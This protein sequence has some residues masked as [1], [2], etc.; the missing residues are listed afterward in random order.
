VGAAFQRAR[1]GSYRVIHLSAFDHP[2]VQQ[3]KLVIPAAVDFKVIDGRVRSECQDRGPFPGTPAQAEHHDFVY[4]LPTLDTPE[5]GTRSD[6]QKGHPGFPLRV[7]RP[8]PRF[9]A[10]VF[11]K[12]PASSESGLF[13]A[14]DVDAA[15][16]RWALTRDP[17]TIPDNVG[18][19]PRAKAATIQ[20]PRRAGVTRPMHCSAR[21]MTRRR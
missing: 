6:G 9:T 2:N 11:G 12:W 14:G 4:A 17:A 15:M 20:R 8:S 18:V 16:A 5:R 19:D 21:T 13:N 3:R 10:Q 7:Y 1:S